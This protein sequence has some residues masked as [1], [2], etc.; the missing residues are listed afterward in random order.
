MDPPTGN[1]V[2]ITPTIKITPE[3]PLLLKFAFSSVTEKVTGVI[4][5]NCPEIN[6]HLLMEKVSHTL[7]IT[8]V[9]LVE[10]N[11]SLADLIKRKPITTR[12]HDK[13]HGKYVLDSLRLILQQDISKKKKKNMTFIYGPSKQ[14]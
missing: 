3:H 7:D 12:T 13:R 8:K 9:F 10:R 14:K 6:S 11:I 1:G 4:L 2:F 5:L